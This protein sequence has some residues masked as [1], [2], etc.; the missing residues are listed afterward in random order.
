MEKNNKIGIWGF[1]VVGKSL[2]KYL[3]KLSYQ[4]EVLDKKD[5]ESQDSNYLKNLNIKFSKQVDQKDIIKF[6]ENNDYIIPSPGI[7]LRPYQDFNSKFLT[8]LDIFY[9][10]W[11]KKI[12]SVTGTLGKTSVVHLLN[13]ILQNYNIPVATGGNIGLAMLD[14]LEEKDQSEY[15]LLELSSFQLE[16]IK[17]FKS[18]IAIWTN[19]YPNHLDRHGTLDEYFNAKLNIILNQENNQKALIPLELQDAILG[20]Q[21]LQERSLCFFSQENIKDFNLIRNQDIV[22]FFDTKENIIKKYFNKNLVNLISINNLPQISYK[23][24][25][26][27]LVSICD[28]L[29]LNLDLLKNLSNLDLPAHR[30]DLIDTINGTEFYNDSKSTIPQ[31]TLAAVEQLNNKNIILFVGGISKGVDRSAFLK[32]LENKVKTVI[33][34]GSEAQELFEKSKNLNII[35]NKFENLNQAF[36]YTTKIMSPGDK[37]LFS[38]AGA[39]FDLFKNY[40]ERGEKFIEL[41][42]NFKEKQNE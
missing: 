35:A 8:E 10:F 37:I 24:N 6:L 42:K 29:E 25:W 27:I 12:I 11:N 41:V 38:P 4:I 36:D 17:K 16:H 30:L 32:N 18:D 9:E 19:F 28:M 39:S 34:F 31:A 20:N 1:G 40:Q 15:A 5:L 33:F 3:S 26:V 21:K 7:D 13:K 14:L 22:Y 2:V 23:S